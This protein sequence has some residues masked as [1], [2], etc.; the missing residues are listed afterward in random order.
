MHFMA[1]STSIGNLDKKLFQEEASGI[2]NWA[3]DGLRCWID[4]GLAPPE[5]VRMAT[6][7]YRVESDYLGTFIEA[8]VVRVKGSRVQAKV[9]HTKYSEWAEPNGERPLGITVFGRMM[10]ERGF[11]KEKT[12]LVHYLDIELV[13]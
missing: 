4:I 7:A 1:Q 9:L 2:L 12:G 13:D 6:K 8:H 5:E 11:V 3:L 10:V